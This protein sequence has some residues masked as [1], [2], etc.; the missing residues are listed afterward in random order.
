MGAEPG[1]EDGSD[2]LLLWIL[3]ILGQIGALG[4]QGLSL[5]A[6]SRV[7]ADR[8]ALARNGRAFGASTL[9]AIVRNRTLANTSGTS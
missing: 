7:L 3:V 5:Q 2:A 4:G 1:H 9:I 8:G 6:I